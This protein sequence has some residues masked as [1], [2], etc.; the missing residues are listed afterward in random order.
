MSKSVSFQFAA[1]WIE[2][3]EL[4]LNNASGLRWPTRVRVMDNRGFPFPHDPLRAPVLFSS[5]NRPK[6][7]RNCS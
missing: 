7:T 5:Q 2:K 4:Q 3:I 1:P 6:S